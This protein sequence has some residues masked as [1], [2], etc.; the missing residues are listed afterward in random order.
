MDPDPWLGG[1]LAVL[2]ALLAFMA[3]LSSLETAVLNARRSRM[4]QG[5]RAAA[6]EAILEAPEQFQTSAHLAKSLCESIVY[7]LAALVGLEQE[8]LDHPG[9]FPAGIPQLLAE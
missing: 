7:A 6:A 8:L 1:A 2:I 5:G 4:P 3:V 9:T